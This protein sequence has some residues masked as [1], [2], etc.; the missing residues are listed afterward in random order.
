MNK[1]SRH[2]SL[3]TLIQ[4]M[5]T[6]LSRLSPCL[7]MSPM[8]VAQ[9]LDAAHPLFDVVVF[10]EAS[11]I[12]VW[13]AIGAIARGRQLI[14]A[15][16]PKQLPPTNFFARTSDTDDDEQDEVQVE[17]LESILDECNAIKLAPQHLNWHYR[18]RHE[19]LIAFSNR[20]Y[21]RNRLVTFPSPVTR[22]TAVSFHSI[23]GV[24]DRSASRTNR[25]EAGAVVEFV[26]AHL[27]AQHGNT[28]DGEWQT[29]GV[30][31]FNAQQ[32]TMIEDLLDAER[33]KLPE[34]EP[35]FSKDAAEYVLVKNLENVQGDE[36]DV[37]V[38]STTYGADASGKR[39]MNFG[40]LNR[41]GGERRLNVAI[42]RARVALHVFC[43]LGPEHIDLSKTRKQG[44]ADLKHFLEYAQH[45]PK[46]LSEAVSAPAE[47]TESPFEQQVCDMLRE[48][49]WTV[50]PQVG[51]SGYR[52][53]LGVVDPRA[54]GRY[55]FGTL[56]QVL[57]TITEL[58]LPII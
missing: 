29:I 50:H 22:D 30:V 24:Y 36:R 18:S 37:M 44:V 13:D 31:T 4:K 42:T 57:A 27:N 45:G 43:S 48:K 54:P 28:T 47:E 34:L 19:S 21:Y 16:D 49:G 35:Y 5:P 52:I 2:M 10:D 3:R 12:P 7:M 32:Q 33:Q 46:A 26:I 8:S 1:K 11:Q 55:L 51:C 56:L 14:V 40:P 15:G 38:F 53:D 23:D 20:K 6:V 9:Y 25:T 41:E 39:S 17:E 58:Y